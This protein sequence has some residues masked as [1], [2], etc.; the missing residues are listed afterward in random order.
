MESRERG[1]PMDT[2]L[3]IGDIVRIKGQGKR[4]TVMAKKRIWF[5]ERY[6]I[7][8]DKADGTLHSVQWVYRSSLRIINE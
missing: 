7:M 1:G 2:R 6:Q 4:A 8:W 5:K 3:K